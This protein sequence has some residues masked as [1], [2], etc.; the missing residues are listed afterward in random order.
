M[1]GY[2]VKLSGMYNGNNIRLRLLTAFYIFII[3]FDERVIAR[4]LDASVNFPA[5]PFSYP[6]P[7][8]FAVVSAGAICCALLVYI[9]LI[10]KPYLKLANHYGQCIWKL[11]NNH[12]RSLT[13]VNWQKTLKDNGIQLS[14]EI[15][16]PHTTVTF[17][18]ILNIFKRCLVTL[19]AYLFHKSC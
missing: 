7:P 5:D 19:G 6:T 9:H 1:V 11:C 17:T 10:S 13:A 14:F 8:R 15:T 3:L 18:Q 2:I 12:V 16:T 4:K